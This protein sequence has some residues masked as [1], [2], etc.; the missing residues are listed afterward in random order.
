MSI[1]STLSYLF[2]SVISFTPVDVDVDLYPVGTVTSR[3]VYFTGAPL[4]FLTS[5]SHLYSQLFA[6]LRITGCPVTLLFA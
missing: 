2:V 1:F 6:E 3:A 4:T 5:E